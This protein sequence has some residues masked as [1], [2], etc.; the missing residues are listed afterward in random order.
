[1]KE[2]A[3][4]LLKESALECSFCTGLICDTQ[5]NLEACREQRAHVQFQARTDVCLG[6]RVR[7]E[8]RGSP[9]LPLLLCAGCLHPG[10]SLGTP[11]VP[12]P[13]LF[14]SGFWNWVCPLGPGDRMTSPPVPLCYLHPVLTWLFARCICLLVNFCIEFKLRVYWIV[15]SL[16]LRPEGLIRSPCLIGISM[17]QRVSLHS[18][19]AE[20][21][22]ETPLKWAAVGYI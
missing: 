21:G 14:L 3:L 19:M 18:C 5:E 13:V 1:M 10:L 16:N 15:L 20:Q 7:E 17:G 2:Q 4:K 11:S 9:C 6:G 8:Q 12:T 22:K